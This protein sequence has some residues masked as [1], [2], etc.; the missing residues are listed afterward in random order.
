MHCGVQI[1][2][3]LVSNYLF[4]YYHVYHSIRQV[5]IGRERFKFNRE[6]IVVIMSSLQIVAD[7]HKLKLLFIAVCTKHFCNLQKCFV[8]L[9]NIPKYPY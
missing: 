4:Y 7:Q 9:Y 2:Q 5:S 6:F 8:N 3:N 1:I